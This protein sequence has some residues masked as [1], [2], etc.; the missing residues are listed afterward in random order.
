MKKALGILVCVISAALLIKLALSQSEPGENLQLSQSSQEST[1]IKAASSIDDADLAVA[2]FA[3]GCFWC[4]ESTFEKLNGVK[5]AVSGYSGGNTINPTYYEVG[6][7]GTGHTETVQIF[8]DPAV[9]SYEALLH[10]FWKDIDPTDPDGQFVDRGDYYRPVI[11]YHNEMEKKLATKSRDEL[12]ASNRFDKPIATGIVPFEK[13]YNAEEYHQDYYK[14]AP[15]RY[16]VYRHGSGRDQFLKKIWGDELHLN[17]GESTQSSG[18]LETSIQDESA[19]SQQVY[20][21]PDGDTIKTT[22][23]R[24]QYE[25]TQNESTEPPFNNKYWNNKNDGIYVDIVTGEPLFSSTTKFPSGTGW[26]S[27]WEPI[28]KNYVVEKVDHKLLV[29]RTEIKS[30]YGDSHLGHVFNDGPAP[31]RLRYCINSAALQFIEKDKMK[32]KGYGKYLA[33]FSQ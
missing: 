2:T 19:V 3:G 25:V 14:K 8:Y 11:F 22:L 21:K 4:I 15:V 33:L 16:K 6:G 17:Y 30:K 23:T 28:D 9:I 1:V 32:E 12:A 5:E 31:T 7:G 26:P 10:R 24:L 18:H 29:P 20:K 27:F 13:F